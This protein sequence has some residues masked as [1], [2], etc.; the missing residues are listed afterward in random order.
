[1]GELSLTV[2]QNN[3]LYRVDNIPVEG[4]AVRTDLT[5]GLA[6]GMDWKWF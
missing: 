6:Y 1:M 2:R 5:V 3:F 4:A